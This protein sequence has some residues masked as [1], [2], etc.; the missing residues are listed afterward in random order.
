[1]MEEMAGLIILVVIGIPFITFMM[2]ASN[3]WYNRKMLEDRARK[4]RLYKRRKNMTIRY[5]MEE[6]VKQ[7]S[8]MKN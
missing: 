3:Y 6:Q 2:A 5:Y 7:A 8:T 4:N 1:M